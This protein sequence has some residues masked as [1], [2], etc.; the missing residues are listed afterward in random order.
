[1]RKP[2]R[3]PT[4]Q[5]LQLAAKLYAPPGG[6]LTKSPPPVVPS[7]GDHEAQ[8]ADRLQEPHPVREEGH[9]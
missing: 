4:K 6:R 8:D 1:M 3:K 2:V 9:L 7:K 5:L